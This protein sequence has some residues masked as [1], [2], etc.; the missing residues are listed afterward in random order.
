MEELEKYR[1]KI[2]FW[3]EIDRQ[4]ILPE[5]T[6]EEV[7]KAVQQVYKKLWKN[8]GCIAQCEFGPGAAPENVYTV[9]ETWSSLNRD[10][11]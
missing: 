7:A 10:I 3:G 4:H 5:G 6:K 1:G 8:G 11:K 9:F 2:T